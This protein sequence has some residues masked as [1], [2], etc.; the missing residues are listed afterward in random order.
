MV[1]CCE[2]EREIRMHDCDV[3]RKLLLKGAAGKLKRKFEDCSK[4]ESEDI[5]V[6]MPAQPSM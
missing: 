6:G 1:Q 5:A 2:Q 3:I 4:L